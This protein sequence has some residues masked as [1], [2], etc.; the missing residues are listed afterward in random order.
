MLLQDEEEVMELIGKAEEKPATDQIALVSERRGKSVSRSSGKEPVLSD[1][2][3]E[4]PDSDSDPELAK[5]KEAMVFLTQAFQKR[6][7]FNKSSNKQ[8]VSTRRDHREK[9]E[10][11]SR[12]EAGKK[13]DKRNEENPKDEPIKCYNCG[14]LGH[15]AKD[16]LK[17]IV[18]NA[19]YYR[20]KLLLDKEKEAGKT[21]MAEDDYWLQVSD[22][23]P[24]DA[25]AHLCFM[26][27]H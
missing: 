17:P 26:G 1:S 9:S 5:M 20:A 23:E 8:R 21:L 11:N 16:C 25:E 3:P 14:R 2:E 13:S 24:E 4:D 22:E 27:N 10:G 19:D 6:K 12:F 15:F 18:R 7:F